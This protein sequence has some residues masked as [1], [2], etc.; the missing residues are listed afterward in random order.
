MPDIQELTHSFK[1]KLEEEI[2]FQHHLALLLILILVQGLQC[3][4]FT[5][6]CVGL[7]ECQLG[8]TGM[9]FSAEL[10]TNGFG[11]T[12]TATP[13]KIKLSHFIK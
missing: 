13:C 10:K 1:E 11:V 8:G 2:Q 12:P 7:Y 5:C 4:G 3:T 6:V 9:E